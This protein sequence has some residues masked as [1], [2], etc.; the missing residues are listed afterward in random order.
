MAAVMAGCF[1]GYAM[2]LLTTIAGTYL[3]VTARDPRAGLLRLFPEGVSMRLVFVPLSLG[4]VLIWTAVGLGAGS[5]FHLLD[6]GEH[7][8]ALG[9]PSAP[10][11]IGVA[12]IGAMPLPFLCLVWPARWWLFAGMSALFVGLFGWAMPFLATR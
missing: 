2:A 9:S 4:T 3:A 12:A 5:A 7:R 8:D 11:L 1:A 10:F 6:A